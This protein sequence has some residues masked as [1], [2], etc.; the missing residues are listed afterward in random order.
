MAQTPRTRIA[1]LVGDLLRDNDLATLADLAALGILG[2][3]TVRHTRKRYASP[4]DIG[5]GACLSLRVLSDEPREDDG[6]HTLQEAVHQLAID[7]QID[8]PLPTEDSAIDPTGLE[9][10]G[11]I[12]NAAVKVL[13]DIA[14]QTQ[15]GRRLRDLCDEVVDLGM[16]NDD[17]ELEGAADEARFIHRIIV[18][19][20]TDVDD[21]NLLLAEGENLP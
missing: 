18:L 9:A 7:M 14:A 21:P 15:D 2:E 1:I 3:V 5:A 13:K 12:G 6:Y 20:R 8:T 10:P 17:D 19:Y 4:E 16:I 11:S